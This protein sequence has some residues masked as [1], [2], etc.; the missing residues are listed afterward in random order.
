MSE[1]TKIIKICT[2]K[3]CASRFSEYIFNR[4]E[5]DKKFYNY[6]ENISIEKSLC[7]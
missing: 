2:G 1:N 4:L 3:R 6:D 5:A 7:M